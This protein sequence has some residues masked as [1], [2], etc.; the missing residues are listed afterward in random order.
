M[1]TLVFL[2]PTFS[3]DIPKDQINHI[4]NRHLAFI[5]ELAEALVEHGFDPRDLVTP[6]TA[7]VLINFQN[8]EIN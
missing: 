5:N 2:Y 3:Y 4:W 6:A 1:K 7:S 8:K